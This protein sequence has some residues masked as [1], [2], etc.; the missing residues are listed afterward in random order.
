MGTHDVFTGA[1]DIPPTIPRRADLA[2][3]FPGGGGGLEA[4]P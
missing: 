1:T 4:T 2:N 3:Q